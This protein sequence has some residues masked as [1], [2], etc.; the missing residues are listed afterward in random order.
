MPP[1][2]IKH[3]NRADHVGLKR[4]HRFGEGLAHER[5]RR[6]VDD[7]LRRGRGH[8]C[9]DRLSLAYVAL[10]ALDALT[11]VRKLEQRRSGHAV[12]REAGHSSSER[13]QPEGE[14]G[15]L[16]T[17]VAGEQHPSIPPEAGIDGATRLG[18]WLHGSGD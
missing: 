13:L 11:H 16:E 1:N 9:R 8:R 3:V 5:L 6:H 14:P 4:L 7:H 15:A 10:D 18:G 12:H 2:R 17:G